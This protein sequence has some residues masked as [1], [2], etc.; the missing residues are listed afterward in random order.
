MEINAASREQRRGLR[1][2]NDADRAKKLEEIEADLNKKYKAIPL[3]DDQVKA[4]NEYMAER[5]KN[6]QR[7]G[8]NQ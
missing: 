6:M 4:L 7:P 8:G 2:L 5:R 3:S 1:D